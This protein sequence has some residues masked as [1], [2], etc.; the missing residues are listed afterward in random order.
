MC[1]KKPE[2]SQKCIKKKKKPYKSLK[3]PE[4]RQKNQSQQKNLNDRRLP[5]MPNFPKLGL[6]K[7]HLIFV[8]L[9]ESVT[10]ARALV[11]GALAHGRFSSD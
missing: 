2:K 9:I 5:K 7:G 10:G 3:M 1:R 6:E 8:H 4:K 11:T